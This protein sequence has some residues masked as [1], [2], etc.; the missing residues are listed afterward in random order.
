MDYYDWKK[1]LESSSEEDTSDQYLSTATEILP[2]LGAGFAAIV[3]ALLIYA[4]IGR[5]RRRRRLDVRLVREGKHE[6]V[7]PAPFEDDRGHGP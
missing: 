4:A 2:F 5:S 7:F 1:S 3:A 6:P